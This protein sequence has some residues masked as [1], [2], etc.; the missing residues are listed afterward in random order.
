VFKPALT[1]IRYTL[2]VFAVCGILAV[3]STFVVHST[4]HSYRAPLWLLMCYVIA[5]VALVIPDIRNSR[6]ARAAAAARATEAA[7]ASNL[8]L[9]A[10]QSQPLS[11]MK[12]ATGLVL[13]GGELCYLQQ[14]AQQFSLHPMHGRKGTYG[15]LSVPIGHGIRL[16][17]GQM[18]QRYVQ[19]AVLK[20]DGTGIVSLTSSRLIF[21]T[22]VGN[23]TISLSH[24]AG[25]H[26]FSDGVRV[27]IENGK[28]LT[29]VTGDT[30]LVI[31]LQKVINGDVVK[32]S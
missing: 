9:A 22:D 18:Q 14:H 11:P 32:A 1:I 27:D 3:L 26:G 13:R 29:F 12:T 17:A 21:N 25:L 19:Q 5:L 23:S 2:A 10:L 4:G 30:Q 16:N 8:R 20:S 7:E 24:I 31:M 15:G 28:P 6:K